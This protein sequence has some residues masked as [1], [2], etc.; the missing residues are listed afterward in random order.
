MRSM[1]V[2]LGSSFSMWGTGSERQLNPS[3]TWLSNWHWLH[4]Y[5]C[6][7]TPPRLRAAGHC[8]ADRGT[9]SG[10][11]GGGAG[12]TG[13]EGGPAGPPLPPSP[14]ASAPTSAVSESAFAPSPPV[15]TGSVPVPASSPGSAAVV[16]SWLPVSGV[17]EVV[18]VAVGL[19]GGGGMGKAPAEG[20]REACALST[21]LPS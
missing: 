16:A 8:A 7:K 14:T 15:G 17:V 4:V 3:R 21:S 20:P 1:R 9:R 2:G 19:G 6:C 10:G 13:R 5:V 11:G 18:V 12:D